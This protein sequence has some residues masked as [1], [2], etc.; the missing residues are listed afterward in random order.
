MNTNRELN[1]RLYVQRMSGFTR[2][3]FNSEFERYM[4]VQSGDVETVKRNFES[5]KPNFTAGKGQLSDD[6]VRNIRYHLIVSVAVISRICVEGG[7]GHDEAYTLGDIFIRRADKCNDYD[8]LLDL[9]EEM[10]VNYAEQMREIKKNNV[11]SLHIRRCIDYIY[12]NL[13]EDLSVKLLAE[14]VG[15]NQTYLSKLFAKETGITIKSF[16]TNAKIN[17]AE[18]LLK[19]SDISCSEISCA[20]GFSSQ[21]AF[22]SVF[23]KKTGKT[24]RQFREQY[25]SQTISL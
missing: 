6:P 9:F 16:I 17:T 8:A 15:L 18:N 12:E 10:L 4:A 5:I 7:L 20:L 14:L 24:P 3:S 21:S 22:I 25:Y 13:H 23:K 19:Y 1:Y 11:I 2:Q